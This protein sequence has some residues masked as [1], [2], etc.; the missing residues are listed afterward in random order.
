MKKHRKSEKIDATASELMTLGPVLTHS[1]EKV[2]L[3]AAA[4]CLLV[5]RGWLLAV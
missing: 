5:L 2:A 3:P 1:V 4:M